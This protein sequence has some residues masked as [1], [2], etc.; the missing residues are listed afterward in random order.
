MEIG[1]VALAF[2]AAI[3]SLLVV[4]ISKVRKR[5]IQSLEKQIEELRNGAARQK[6]IAPA[7][8]S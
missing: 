8:A 5:K 6:Q 1:A 4:S 7:K 3:I 2:A